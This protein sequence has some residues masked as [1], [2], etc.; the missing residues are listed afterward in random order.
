MAM[1][2]AVAIAMAMAVAVVAVGVERAGKR[3]DE[4]QREKEDADEA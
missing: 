3:L 1:T 4:D 2:I